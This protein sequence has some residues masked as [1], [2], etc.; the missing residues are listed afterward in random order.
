M[1][2]T[3]APTASRRDCLRA[4]LV[5]GGGALL[6]PGPAALAAAPARPAGGFFGIPLAGESQRIGFSLRDLDGRLRRA[7]S[8]PGSVLVLFFGFLSCP[9]ICPSTLAELSA[10][11]QALGAQGRSVRVAFAT[12]DPERDSAAAMRAW[13][14]HFGDDLIGLRDSP[15][16]IERTTQ[17]LRLDWQRVPGPTPDR[18]T[19]D[20]GVQSYCF[21][22]RGRLRLLMRP[23]PTPKEVASDWRRL[24]DG[25]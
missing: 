1:K 14:R 12:L 24:L 6:S 22:T 23:G 7:D 3:A 13:L 21:D 25:A 8:F 18:Y 5:A 20:H 2:S 9:S 16:A 10:A 4:M 17:A 15:E 11:R 19:I